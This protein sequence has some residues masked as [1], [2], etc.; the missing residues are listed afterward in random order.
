M[1]INV[2]HLCSLTYVF[3]DGEYNHFN[4]LKGDIFFICSSQTHNQTHHCKV[5]TEPHRCHNNPFFGVQGKSSDNP[6][7]SG[8]SGVIN[9]LNTL[10][11][12][13]TLPGMRYLV[14]T[15][16]VSLADLK[17]PG[18]YHQ[19]TESETLKINF[20]SWSHLCSAILGISSYASCSHC[21]NTG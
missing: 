20:W 4:T 5:Q 2:P 15:V 12:R 8:W 11:F 9:W 18:G 14:W 17:H 6:S 1:S 13:Y 3:K 10:P 7:S 21:W 16:P 19:H